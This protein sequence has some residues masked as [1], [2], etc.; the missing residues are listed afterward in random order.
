MS[1][2][3]VLPLRVMLFYSTMDSE[4][5][6]SLLLPTGIPTNAEKLWLVVECPSDPSVTL[7]RLTPTTHYCSLTLSRTSSSNESESG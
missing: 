4:A 7:G 1:G 3:T 5:M 6:L 2:S